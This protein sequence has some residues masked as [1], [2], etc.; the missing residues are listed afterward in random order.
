MYSTIFNG[1]GNAFQYFF[2]IL[3]AIG[4]FV[5]ILFWCTIAI[6]CFYWLFYGMKLERGGPNYL[7]E[8]QKEDEI[9]S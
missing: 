3:P 8:P 5:A 6:G 2:K 7:G 1:I 4:M 9:R